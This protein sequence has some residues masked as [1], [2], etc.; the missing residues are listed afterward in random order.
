M[1]RLLH[2]AAVLD[3]LLTLWWL[4]K[5]APMPSLGA[6]TAPAPGWLLALAGVVVASALGLV[7]A[8][9]VA[10]TRAVLAPPMS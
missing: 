4:A 5:G 9:V 7:V 6:L 10:V 3:T 2:A 1:S 8:G